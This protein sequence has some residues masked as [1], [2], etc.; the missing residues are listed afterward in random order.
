MENNDLSPPNKSGWLSALKRKLSK[1]FKRSRQK[2]ENS[3]SLDSILDESVA[4][5]PTTAQNNSTTSQQ[6]DE[7]NELNHAPPVSSRQCDNAVAAT[8]SSVN[9]SRECEEMK[10]E[11]SKLPCYWPGLTRIEAQKLLSNQPNGS[12]LVR[13]SSEKQSF[14]LSFR[15]NFK[16]FHSRNQW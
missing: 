3:P 6:N 16:T 9:S 11:L 15:T 8:T 2:C 4:S 7:A 12:F 5:P 13:D 14:T 1:K 10:K